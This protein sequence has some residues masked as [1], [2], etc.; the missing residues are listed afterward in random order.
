MPTPL[1]HPPHVDELL[2]IAAVQGG[3]AESTYLW[4]LDPRN[5]DAVY[6][7][8][9]RKANLPIPTKAGY[10]IP[11][12][13]V[14]IKTDNGYGEKR[15][16]KGATVDRNPGITDLGE[17]YNLIHLSRRGQTLRVQQRDVVEITVVHKAWPVHGG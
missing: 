9:D 7:E 6:A 11:G 10:L 17:G 15:T 1:R 2:A 12:S 14:D 8:R 16:I 13:T 3:Q 4:L 5:T